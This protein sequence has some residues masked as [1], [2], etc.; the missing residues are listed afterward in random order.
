M[1]VRS[2][3]TRAWLW[4]TAWRFRAGGSVCKRT[5]SCRFPSV[6]S[7]FFVAAELTAPCQPG[8]TPR[9]YKATYEPIGGEVAK[10]V[11]PATWWSS[12]QTP[13]IPDPSERPSAVVGEGA[14]PSGG[15][16]APPA[17]DN[18][19]SAIAEVLPQRDPTDDAPTI[20]SMNR[21]RFA[22]DGL[23]GRK[24]GHFELIEPLGAGG[25]AAVIR[26]TDLQLGRVVALKGLPPEMAADPQ[27][28]ARFKSEAR[29]AA[30]LDHENIARVYFC[31]EDQGLHFIPFKFVA[32][33]D[34]RT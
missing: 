1:A 9:G 10:P 18:P 30:K 21:P 24:L 25:M 2:S 28:I 7:W 17:T 32:V 5:R 34:R 26:A 16:P 31:G 6:S 19:L 20:I 33:Q 11:V 27:N 14:P 8:Y 3:E 4:N 12:M 23:Q 15:P 29:A 22:G 13:H